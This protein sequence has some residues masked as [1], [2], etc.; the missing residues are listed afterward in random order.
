MMTKVLRCVSLEIRKLSYYDDL[1]DVDLFL[2]EFQHEVPKDHH[3]QE[4][5]LALCTMLV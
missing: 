3:F 2:D 1:I 4:L 5:E